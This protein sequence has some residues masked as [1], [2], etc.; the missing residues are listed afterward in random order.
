MW[1]IAHLRCQ[2]CGTM[3]ECR[4]RVDP[5]NLIRAV[6]HLL[7]EIQHFPGANWEES[8]VGSAISDVRAEMRK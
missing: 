6:E 4:V 1:K 2:R 5:V 3:N 8:P 7:D